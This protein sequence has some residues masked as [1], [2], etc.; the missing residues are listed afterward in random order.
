MK[1]F[2]ALINQRGA[3]FGFDARMALMIFGVMSLVVGFY[4]IGRIKIAKNAA[5]IKELET[6]DSAL[7][8]YQSDMG[9]F[10]LFTYNTEEEENTQT[11]KSLNVLW[12]KSKLREG[13]KPLWNG[14]YTHRNTRHHR[15]FGSFSVSFAQAN[16]EDIC[17]TTSDCY[18]WITLTKVPVKVWQEV[19]SYVD[20]AGGDQREPIHK[21]EK[22]GRVHAQTVDGED[23]RTLFYRSVKRPK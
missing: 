5:L 2:H 12:D 3:L 11:H 1:F 23:T 8:H 20:E 6:L 18:A 15:T 19:N 10:F 21:A 4:S 9:V 22:S 14:P 7:Q 13:F 16:L 17:T